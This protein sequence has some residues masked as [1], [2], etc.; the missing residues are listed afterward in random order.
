[1]RSNDAGVSLPAV[2]HWLRELQQA[3]AAAAA[4]KAMA[5]MSAAAAAAAA[6]TPA[7]Q[8]AASMQRCLEVLQH[9]II[10]SIATKIS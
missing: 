9:A 7:Q 4:A 1:M 3:A 10:S 2:Q 5:A 6:F 8:Q